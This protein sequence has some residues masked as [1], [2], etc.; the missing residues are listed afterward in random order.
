MLFNLIVTV[1]VVAVLVSLCFQPDAPIT[2][3]KNILGTPGYDITVLDAPVAQ[4]TLLDVL[5]HLL[6]KTR[7]GPAIRRH[8][9]NN[10]RIA[11]LRD[12]ASQI[13]QPPMSF[14]MRRVNA[15]KYAELTS[16]ESVDAA[17][18]A[19]LTGF[20]E[21]HLP[22]LQALYPRTIAEYH[23]FYQQGNLPSVVMQRTLSTIKTWE[24]QDFRVFS[25][26]LT[27]EVLQAARESDERWKQGKPLSM[28]DGV[29]VAFKVD[30]RM[31][32]DVCL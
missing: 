11:D 14:P 22:A 17:I 29:P 19:V 4:S 31:I 3:F 21:N 30:Y 9:L 24:S 10:N 8:L 32:Y 6:T 25:S 16:Q 13:E 18:A 27:E 26:I 15:A 20:S 7:F 5:S 2:G 23:A 1:A 28:F 12:L